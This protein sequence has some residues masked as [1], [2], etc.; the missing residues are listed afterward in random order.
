[1]VN[2][3]DTDARHVTPAE[4]PA[5]WFG[6]KKHLSKHII[7]RIEA[8]PHECYAEP[9]VGLG[10]VF[11]RR[12]LKPKSEI[13]NDANG[14]IANLF[15]IMRDHGAELARQFDWSLASRNE[16]ARLIRTP[17]D[18]LTDIRRAARFAYLQRLSFGGKPATDVTQGQMAP[19]VHHPSR[20][21]PPRM[22]R[23]I[24][25]A[26]ERLQDVH[27]ECL[28]WAEFIPRYDRS[29]TLFYIDPPYFGH[30]DDYGRDLFAKSDF[31]KMADMLKDIE[32]R[33]ILSI[34]GTPEIREMFDWAHVE[35]VETRY[36]ANARSTRRVREVLISKERLAVGG[37]DLFGQTW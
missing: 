6:G 35:E 21:T 5:P 37:G 32:G 25:A 30:E 12:R 23:L 27:I 31:V 13:I 36:S 28:D 34:N 24:T 4:P 7:E 1:M 15:R 18:T 16:F 14:E 17:P 10:G 2:T 22:T 9:F 33:F 20:L 19:S 3:T 8:T 26:H 29:F 11:L